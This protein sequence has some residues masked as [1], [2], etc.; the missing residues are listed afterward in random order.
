MLHSVALFLIVVGASLFNVAALSGGAAQDNTLEIVI[1]SGPHAG[2]YRPPTSPII[3]MDAKQRQFTAAYKDFDAGDPKKLSEAVIN[4]ANPTDAGTKRGDVL[5]SFGDPARK[6]VSQ[7]TI[8]IPT[9]SAG[10]LTFT[11]NGKTADLSFRGRTKDGTP[12][13]ITARC[14]SI[15][16]M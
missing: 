4:I 9:D 6:P 14:S 12:V 13:Q 1:G 5:I 2:T 15:D 11:R 3:C 7:Y 16:A 10:P 8:S